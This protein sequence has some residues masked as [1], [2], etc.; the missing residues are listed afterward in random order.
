MGMRRKPWW[1]RKKT[2]S[3]GIL[4]ALVIIVLGFFV[5]LSRLPQSPNG[6]PG[7]EM[8]VN[9]QT[10]LSSQVIGQLLAQKGVIDNAFW[11]RVYLWW[12]H[13]GAD[14]QAGNYRFHSGMTFAQV[15]AELKAGATRYNTLMVTI[16]EGYTVAQIATLL[17]K[18][19]LCSATAFYQAV[20]HGVYP[21]SFIKQI[22]SHAHIKVRL[23]GYL[24]PSTYA[25]V[26][27]E[28][29]H[30]MVQTMLAQM[31]DVLTQKRLAIIHNEGLTVNQ[32]LTI[33][34]MVEREAQVPRE[35]PLVA[36]V[37]FNRLHH[38]PPMHLRIDATV[39]YA[40][41]YYHG[42]TPILTLQNLQVN[43]PYNTY[44][45]RGLPPGPIAN[46]GLASIQAVLHPAHTH[47]LYYVA[48]NNG[49]GSSYFATTYAQQL[50]NEARSQANATKNSH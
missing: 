14:L 48:K 45:H 32:V 34:S 9:I 27:G 39:E 46:P 26:R 8:W 13:Q 36:S 11:F 38:V 10:G 5:G 19:K 28:S 18:D 41:G 29:A 6:K 4:T 35:R 24:F 47:Y 22:P 25:F 20:D 43:S 21:E 7:R 49:T 2:R 42:F 31:A 40:L 1:K 15:V 50:Q 16:P 17:E 37:I 3:L 30:Q 44:Q 33:A 12:S 23:E